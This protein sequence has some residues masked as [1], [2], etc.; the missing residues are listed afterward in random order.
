MLKVMVELCKY[1]KDQLIVDNG[2]NKWYISCVDSTDF[3]PCNGDVYN[4]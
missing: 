2:I 4:I 1:I 3:Q